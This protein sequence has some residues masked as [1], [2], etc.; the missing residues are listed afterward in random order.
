[1]LDPCSR[2]IVGLASA[3][4]L[5]TSLPEAALRQAIRGRELPVGLLHHSDR[6]V[7]YASERY[8]QALLRNGITPSMSCRAKCYDNALAESFWGTRKAELVA[9]RRF[10][11][12]HEAWLAIPD[13]EGKA[14]S[15]R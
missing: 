7:Q 2:P 8:G 1:V 9:R 12:R 14:R 13:V 4:H 10:A 3:G 6:G 15:H 5:E 11:T